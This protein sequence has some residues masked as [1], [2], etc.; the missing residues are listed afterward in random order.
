NYQRARQILTSALDKLHVMA[1]ALIKFET[2]DEEQ[3]KDIMAGRP[4]RPPSG[5]DDALINK[6]PTKPSDGQPPAPI[7]SPAGQH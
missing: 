6:P 1:D 3:L 2:I 7:G 4:P 5:W